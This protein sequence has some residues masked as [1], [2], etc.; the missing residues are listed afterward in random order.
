MPKFQLRTKSRHSMALKGISL[1]VWLQLSA[2]S[3]DGCAMAK[4]AEKSAKL[5]V[6][7]KAP[8]GSTLVI[9]NGCT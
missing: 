1:R 4:K 8:E 6:W 3:S 7:D 5:R 9:E 2:V